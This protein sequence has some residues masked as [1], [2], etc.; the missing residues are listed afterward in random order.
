MLRM[1]I[2]NRYPYR[3]PQN[4][5]KNRKAHK[6]KEKKITQQKKQQKAHIKQ[7]LN[8][9]YRIMHRI[10]MGTMGRIAIGDRS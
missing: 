4:N 9:D 10:P 8:K 7:I 2:S 6:Q 5:T 3:T 1:A